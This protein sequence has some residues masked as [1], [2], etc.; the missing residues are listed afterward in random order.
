MPRSNDPSRD[1]AA[2]GS[3][4]RRL[5]RRLN[6]RLGRDTTLLLLAVA[7]GV[8]GGLGAV[9]FR[10]LIAI[11]QDVAWG[12]GG[13]P[14]ER[15]LRAP[16]TMRLLVP[17][18]G[19]LVVG[20]IVRFIAPEAKGH[21]VPE[22]MLA[23]AT[24]QGVIRPVVGVAKSVAS[25]V[26]I[27]SGGSAGREGPMVQIGS[28]LA[29]SLGQWLRLPSDRLRVCVGCGAA[30]GI[31]A[32]FNAPIAGA[33]F[34]SEVIL[35]GFHASAF[36]PAVVASV[37][38]TVIARSVYG[39]EI[40]FRIPEYALQHPGEMLAYAA[41]GVAAGVVGVLFI[42]TLAACESAFDRLHAVPLVAQPVIGGIGVGLIALVAPQAMGV[43]YDTISSALVG[44]IAPAMLLGLLGAKL[45]ATS[46]TLGSGGSGGV[47]APS[48][49]LGAMIG[50]AIGHA[51]QWLPFATASP[52]AY[53]VVGMGA[54]V[55]ATTHA[56]ITAILIIFELTGDY[57]VIVALMLSCILSNVV[58]RR[59]TRPSIYTVKLL[60]RGIDVEAGQEV[61]V[62]R[63]LKVRDVMRTDIDV[64]ARSAS[65]TELERRIVESPHYEFF[66]VDADGRLT[67][68][69]S[70]DDLRRSLPHLREAG[71]VVIAQ[72][73]ATDVV[74]SLREDDTLDTA[75]RQFGKRT[76]EELP[77]L[78]AGGGDVPVGLLNRQDV[79]NA[80]NREILK[81]DLGGGL[82]SRIDSAV[83]S[84]T[85]ET[86]GAHVVAEMPVP[87]G[88][89]GRDLASLRLPQ[90]RGVQVILVDRGESF[91][92]HRWVAPSR[93]TV[94]NSGE[95]VVVF[96]LR[97]AV[98]A[99]VA[100]PPGAA[101]PD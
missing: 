50:G 16:W 70:I 6:L 86:V 38:A 69:I 7:I 66:T 24:R 1:L 44:G 12:V 65:V 47:F 30:S 76:Y 5:L 90:R 3:L 85:W 80:Y 39:D 10:W 53:S 49:F 43:G 46:I 26:C 64:V 55:A 72:D 15:V 68:V 92:S 79:I 29:S 23:V 32:T 94:L 78:P 58:A 28:A 25:A 36:G 19:G 45:V 82:S 42:K 77:V 48:M 73:L 74:L 61:N 57:R 31:A 54:V 63:R 97:P 27:A 67:G 100:L 22:V 34:A 84:R 20:L 83:T 40:A 101:E 88:L 18:A 56:P 71:G 14:L 60:R 95:R 96:G 41:L 81:S 89:A 99:L 98:E 8:M 13:T 21:G 59:L 75:M 4:G 51:A 9:F 35:G 93:D 91:G 17:A 2:S 62:L 33:F 11:M 87:P 37:V 52:G